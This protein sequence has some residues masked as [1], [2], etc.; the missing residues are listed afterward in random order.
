MVASA[1]GGPR[2][3][4]GGVRIVLSPAL[5]QGDGAPESLIAAIDRIERYPSHTV[6][7]YEFPTVSIA[8]HYH[9]ETKYSPERLSIT[10]LA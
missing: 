1:Q 3:R 8:E 2:Q 10:W 9:A 4:R 6:V 7:T 5:V